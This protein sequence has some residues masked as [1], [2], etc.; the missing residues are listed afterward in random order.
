[1]TEPS[2]SNEVKDFLTLLWRRKWIVVTVTVVTVLAVWLVDSS[3]A[4]TYQASTRVL[5]PS[6]D[7]IATSGSGSTAT[8]DAERRLANE[9][10]FLRRDEVRAAVIERVGAS[11]GVG[12]TADARADVIIITARAT[13]PARAAEI[14]NAYA[15]EYIDARLSSTI[16]DN[17]AAAS[18]LREEM[19]LAQL[20]RAD[21]L[22]PL[23][24]LDRAIQ[25]ETD[26]EVIAD[27]NDRRDQVSEDLQPDLVRIDATLDSLTASLD[28]LEIAERLAS[29]GNPT[30][31]SQARP[32]RTPVSPN[33]TRDLALALVAGFVL[34]CGLA[35]L[36]DL[37][38]ESIKDE[39]D[40]ARLDLGLPVL[41]AIPS[42]ST[43][44][45]DLVMDD[46]DRATEAEA[47]RT[48][49]TSLMFSSVDRPLYSLLVT[50]ANA[51]EGKSRVASNLAA[52]L[53]LTQSGEPIGL[54]DADWRRP[55]L[56][57]VFD[58]P[59]EPGFSDVVL[60]QQELGDA[61]VVAPD[62]PRLV[63]LTAGTSPPNPAE[64]LASE[65]AATVIGALDQAVEWLVVDSAPVLP[66]S[67]TLT[68]A[69]KVDAVVLVV[70]SGS[71]SRKALTQAIELLEQSGATV[72]GLVLNGVSASA[73]YGRSR[74]D[75]HYTGSPPPGRRG[76]KRG[77]SRR[78]DAEGK[79]LTSG[80]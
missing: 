18:V 19:A 33:T 13:D 70:R 6:G 52:A 50:S 34:G 60:G 78:S 11:P 27:L 77:R 25:A 69:P 75:Y 4:E 38:D 32:N 46:P 80:S 26:E 14:A 1:M 49:R 74:H 40:L 43:R 39:A 24:E 59:K 67:D 71:T 57:E 7:A 44:Q 76:R 2:T 55:R 37:L 10:E 47:F 73:R 22:T 20:Q 5:V 35:V 36:V 17:L 3:R 45:G 41:A 15:E 48:L 16:E 63:L 72:A 42:G 58:I 65:R 51:S 79:A 8:K 54:L 29:T 53:T 12:A 21:L 61:L 9:I 30:I 68:I 62:N 56:H 23:V 64:V 28:D 66:V 31:T